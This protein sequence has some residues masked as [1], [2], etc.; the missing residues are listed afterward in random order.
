MIPE[1]QPE[2]QFVPLDTGVTLHVRRWSGTKRPFVLVHGLSSNCQTWEMVARCLAE[3][4]HAVVTVD[5]RGHGLSDKPESGYNFASITSDLAT[6]IHELKLGVS[7]IVGG[8][9]WGG[10]VVLELAARYPGLCHG[11]ALVDGGFLDL[12]HRADATWDRISVQLRP[13]D[14]DGT[15][16][17]VL[18]DNV[19]HHN[20]DWSQEG[21][22]ATLANFEVTE[23]G[24]IRRRL[25]IPYHMKILRAL[26]EQ[27][28]RELYPKVKKPVLICPAEDGSNPEWAAVK[29]AQV[30]AAQFG[31]AVAEVHWF[32]QTHH[33]IHIHRPNELAS[34]FLTTASTGIWR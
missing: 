34:L 2:D 21:V 1:I 28:P 24:T 12:Q 19:H 31:L 14:M 22:E 16:I 29:G 9:S 11:L 32:H 33:D 27:R 30:D 6:L 26:W 20:P 3:A 15:P 5:Q 17:E 4:D 18:R 25:S 7:P 13:A 23:Q 8:Q 10:N